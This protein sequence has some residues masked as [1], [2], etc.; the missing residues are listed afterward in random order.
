MTITGTN[1]NYARFS[2]GKGKDLRTSFAA[3]DTAITGITVGTP[4]TGV[5]VNSMVNAAAAIAYSKLAPLTA[6]YML[7]G[8]GSNVATAVAITG[9]IAVS[10]AGVVSIT[11]DSIINADIKTDA[12]IAWS[13][14]ATS[15]DI[16]ATGTVTDLTIASEAQGDVLYRNATIWTRL[17]AGTAGQALITAGAGSNPYWG[18]PASTLASKLTNTYSIESGTYDVIHV[19]T[20]Q[21]TSAPT[22][23]IP[24][25]AGAA[26]TYAFLGLAQTF[27]GVKTFANEG[28][29]ILDTNASHDLVL[30]AGSDLT[31][32]RIL[33]ITTGDAARTVT[34]GGAITTTGDLITVGDDSLTFTTGGATN[35]TLPTTGTI[36]SLAGV[37]TFTNKTHDVA[38]TT[39]GA[40]GALTK[41]M[42][43][44]LSGAT[45]D[46]TTTLTFVHTDDR[47]VTFPNFNGT[48]ATLAGTETYTNKTL[49][50]TTCI[51]GANGALTKTLGFDLSA[52][53]AG[54]KVTLAA[55]AGTAVTVTIPNATDTLVGKATADVFTNKTLDCDGTGNVLSNVNATEL[56]SVAL[57]GTGVI[58]IP[59][60]IIKTVTNLA[61]AGENIIENSAF[62]FL[63]TGAELINSSAPD[64]S[65]T[66]QICQGSVGAVGTAITEAVA[67]DNADK[68]KTVATNFDDATSTVASGASGDLCVIGDASGTLDGILIVHCIRID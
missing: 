56:D 8:N 23:T 37:E 47:A 17:A 5:V 27:T 39:F 21:T 65:A 67:A 12:A 4:S 64:A 59:F 1:F 66:W 43:I 24:D 34:L 25:F 55:A 57:S 32:D 29:H 28:I 35:V 33:T 42:K 20:T 9:D 60:C 51:F 63:V 10:N 15:T 11:G 6:T 2:G 22:L 62:K 13:K 31:A 7:V 41:A 16:S 36:A 52:L 54:N 14:M 19:I 38:T 68:I 49:T 48:L 46:K 30:K 26:D 44:S 61:V 50:D 40:N 58:G 53:T 3:V 18:E 45:A